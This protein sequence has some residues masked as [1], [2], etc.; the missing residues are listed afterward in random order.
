MPTAQ[1]EINVGFMFTTYSQLF[2]VSKPAVRRCHK[3]LDF[4]FCLISFLLNCIT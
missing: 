1:A 2:C 4:C 3:T